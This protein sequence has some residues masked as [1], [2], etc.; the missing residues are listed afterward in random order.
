MCSYMLILLQS[1]TSV[2]Y[3]LICLW[4]SFFNFLCKNFFTGPTKFFQAYER[5]LWQITLR[6][7]ALENRL[8]T[9]SHRPTLGKS[10]NKVP[11]MYCTLMIR[12]KIDKA[13]WWSM[14]QYKQY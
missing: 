12:L 9:M 11:S 4:S 8:C 3:L 6:N 2:Y 5:V 7:I 1:L 14:I 13:M 10:L